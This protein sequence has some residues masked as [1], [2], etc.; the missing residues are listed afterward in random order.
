MK[1]KLTKDTEKTTYNLLRNK[2]EYSIQVSNVPNM[3]IYAINIRKV[4][5]KGN[6][7]PIDSERLVNNIARDFHTLTD[8]KYKE[9]CCIWSV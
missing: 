6:Y 7:Y 4:D 1:L 2:D 3:K 8:N 9:Y 5:K